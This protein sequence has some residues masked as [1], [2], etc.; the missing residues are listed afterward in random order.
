[1]Y[2]VLLVCLVMA[3]YSHVAVASSGQS[4]L[5]FLNLP[6]GARAMSLGQGGFAAIEGPEA[7]FTNP[8]LL[9]KNA[10][11]FACHQE[12]LL[13]THSEAASAAIPLGDKYTMALGMHL[14]SPG[15]ITRYDANN[16][17]GGDINAGD[18]LVR[19]GLS[20]RGE[21]SYGFSLSYYNQRLDDRTGNGFGIGGG[22]TLETD[23]GRYSFTAENWGPDFSI[24][25]SSSPLP[26]RLS[27]SGLYFLTMYPV[28]LSFDISYRNHDS[29]RGALGIEYSPFN[30]L[31][32]ILG[33]NNADFISM[34]VRF[35]ADI[36]SI[37]YSYIP[38]SDFGDRH[39]F[40]IK[41][42]K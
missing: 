23:Y 9:G 11:V 42:S 19:L 38:K 25:G 37:D 12:L 26:S 20:K 36:I 18:R 40:D 17:K 29:F 39:I 2:R 24:A 34:G 28:D 10:G 21:I 35:T 3:F 41:I 15:E 7:I 30:G 27:L 31:G 13:D 22:I 5:D 8:S 4:A 14:F 33:G 1:M 16:Q 6:A 32:L